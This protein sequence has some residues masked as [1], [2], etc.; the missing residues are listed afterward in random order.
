[1]SNH[2]ISSIEDELQNNGMARIRG[3]VQSRDSR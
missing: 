2:M 3:V 1:M